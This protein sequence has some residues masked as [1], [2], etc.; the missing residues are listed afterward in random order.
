MLNKFKSLSKKTSTLIHNQF[1][2]LSTNKLCITTPI[3]YVNSDPHIGH[4]YTMIYTD[5]IAK[6]KRINNY[7]VIFSTGMSDHILFKRKELMNMDRKSKTQQ[8]LRAYLKLNIATNILIF[9]ES[10]LR[11]LR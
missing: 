7:D 2:R 9:L 4:L 3:F 1:M 5:A 8:N 11:E 10:S 6:W